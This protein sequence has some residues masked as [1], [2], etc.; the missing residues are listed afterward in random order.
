[1]S[2][3]ALVPPLTARTIAILMHER[4]AAVKR[5]YLVDMFADFWR[6]DGHRVVYLQGVKEFV[7]ADV[8]IVHIDLSVVPD[9]Y[10]EFA[11]RYPAVLNGDVKDIR[12]STYSRL[13]LHRG[14]A[15]EKPV[16]VKS[17]LNYAGLP[18]RVLGLAPPQG[19]NPRFRSPLDYRIYP[20]LQAVPAWIFDDPDLVVERFLP[21]FSGGEYHMRAMG[22]LGD[23]Y[24]CLQ[25]TSKF[26]IVNGSSIIRVAEVEPHPDIIAIK[27]AT[28][29]DY[30]KFDYVIHE[31]QAYLLD[32]N[33]TVGKPAPTDDAEVQAG[34][35]KR[36]R[37]LYRY[38]TPDPAASS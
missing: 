15:Y 20:G 12:K 4:Q 33:K 31:G 35:R 22:F 3:P 10:L 29:F 23:S 25:M 5:D 36:A 38:F 1:M 2:D 13:L 7:P 8:L 28:R 26:P 37:E 14:D 27:R 17:N 21:E 9:E 6:E 30:G 19:S 16:I 24:S 32:M 11:R 18:E 34:R